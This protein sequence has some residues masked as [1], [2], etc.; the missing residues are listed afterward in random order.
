MSKADKYSSSK[1]EEDM[2]ELTEK[3]AMDLRR[4]IRALSSC[5]VLSD[6]W[7]ECADTFGRIATISDME[8]KLSQEKG[9]GEWLRG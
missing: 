5:A 8:S 3:L 6:P 9:G 4:N 7:L 1:G 2:E